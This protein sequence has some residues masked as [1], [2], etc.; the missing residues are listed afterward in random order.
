MAS[1]DIITLKNELIKEL[2]KFFTKDRLKVIRKDAHAKRLPIACGITVHMGHNCPFSCA[3]CY[4]EEMGFKFSETVPYPLSGKEIALALL[5]NPAFVPGKM[6]TFIALGSVADPFYPTVK[7]KTLEFIE[8]VANYLKNP[9]QFST[10]MLID[11]ETASKLKEKSNGSSVSPLVTIVSLKEAKK[12]EPKA[13]SPSLRFKTIRNLSEQGFKVFTFIRPVIPGIT[14]RDA[15]EIIEKSKEM[16]ATGVVVGSLRV[17]AGILNRLNKA[18]INTEGIIKRIKGQVTEK[19]VT[20]DARDLKEAIIQKAIQKGL[21][22]YRSACCA[23]AYAASVPCYG[24]C[25][26]TKRCMQCPNNC[27]SKLPH[28]NESDVAYYLKEYF[29]INDFDINVTKNKIQIITKNKIPFK[30]R[31]Q[32]IIFLRTVFRR[33]VEFKVKK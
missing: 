23:N 32:I 29:K 7:D 20:I 5:Y 11:S 14:D 21:L 27:L 1:D 18:G 16:G 31:Q 19:Q 30:K 24:L 15:N 13:P 4:I 2:E 22:A 28:V 26:F 3:Y 6:G 9:V 10:K 33:F 8:T 25:F 12:L 17:N